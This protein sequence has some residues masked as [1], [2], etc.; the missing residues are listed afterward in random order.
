MITGENLE[1]LCGILNSSIVSWYMKHTAVTTG[2]GL[3]SV[4]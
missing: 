4:G 1:Y 3:Y 2:M